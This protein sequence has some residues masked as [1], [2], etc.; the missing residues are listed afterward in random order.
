MFRFVK[1]ARSVVWISLLLPMAAC[2]AAP[3]S[4]QANC[5]T[6]VTDTR[7]ACMDMIRRGLDVSCNTYLMA[8]GTAM[9]QASGNLF[10]VGDANQSAADSFCAT[11]V[12][13]LRED[14]DENADSMHP[15]DQTGPECSALAERFESRC[16]ANLGKTA[17]AGECKNAARAFAMSGR[18]PHEQM[19]SIAGMQ[20]PKE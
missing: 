1:R 12:D 2:G 4:Q 15:Q 6:L 10:E 17:L 20:L 16:M 18:M 14:R 5:D 13:K 3:D 11:Y 8:I 9:D 7:A 19:C